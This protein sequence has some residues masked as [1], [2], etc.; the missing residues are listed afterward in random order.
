MSNIRKDLKKFGANPGLAT[1][2]NPEMI[3]ALV[4]DIIV[5]PT[6]N[7]D[8]VT[9]EGNFVFKEGTAFTRVYLTKDSQ[10]AAF[11]SGGST[12]AYG[13]KNKI[14]GIL[15]LSPNSQNRR[16]KPRNKDK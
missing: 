12:D 11:E 8:G 6:L 4:D 16:C 1:P 9:W 15:H 5:W 3:A 14:E 7:A 2:K 13:A 10:K